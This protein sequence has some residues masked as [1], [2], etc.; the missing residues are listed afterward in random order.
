MMSQ[1][2]EILPVDR[3]ALFSEERFPLDGIFLMEARAG[4]S[5]GDRQSLMLREH[6]QVLSKI[7]TLELIQN[8][9]SL[10]NYWRL[11]TF[12]TEGR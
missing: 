6:Y 5:A 12:F 3:L 9:S 11:G 8:R 10:S 7:P 2:G 4:D 1:V